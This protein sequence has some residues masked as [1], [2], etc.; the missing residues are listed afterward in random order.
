MSAQTINKHLFIFGATVIF[1]LSLPATSLAAKVQCPPYSV[2]LV[3]NSA[4]PGGVTYRSRLE[5]HKATGGG[6]NGKWLVDRFEQENTYPHSVENP[7]GPLH[8]EDKVQFGAGTWMK[9]VSDTKSNFFLSV[10]TDGNLYLDAV[11]GKIGWTATGVW[12]GKIA[13][14]K[15]ELKFDANN[16]FAP[17]MTGDIV[18]IQGGN[19]DLSVNIKNNQA[20]FLFDN[21][22]PGRL[23]IE[24]S[25]TVIPGDYAE[26]I[27]WTLPELEGSTRTTTPP[28]GSGANIK[29]TYLGLPKTNSSF[30]K[31]AVQA[32]LDVGACKISDSKEIKIFFPRDEKNNPDGNAPNWF[33]YWSQTSARTG[34]AKF[35]GTESHCE[36]A[37]N[38][39]DGTVGFYRAKQLDSVYYICDLAKMGT[40]FPFMTVQWG[41]N[42]ALK[43]V[44]V[45]GIDTF[46]VASHH[47]NGHYTHFKTWWFQHKANHPFSPTEDMNK[48]S[49]KDTIETQLDKDQDMIPDTQEAGL[50]FDP[51]KKY[52]YPGEDDDEEIATWKIEAEWKIGSADKEDWA[53][54]G[55]QW[56]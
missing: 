29:V 37:I 31:K 39:T 48:N 22:K 15:M 26:S 20:N 1:L 45:T 18:E 8:S 34:P 54:P 52:T 14:K 44:P 9:C 49:V 25:A 46:A 35:K 3:G 42:D 24:A 6:Y 13:G 11:G 27:K 33:Y 21:N 38:R 28:S 41:S 55:K 2:V 19:L 17:L 5:M 47:E 30:G 4:M 43:N 56:K 32:M 12:I 23:E 53:N 16:P 50:G 10:C 51:T 36:E 40:E 7:L